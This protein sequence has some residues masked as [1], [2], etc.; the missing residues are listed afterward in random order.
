[1]KKFTSI[2][3]A[4]TV[5]LT[6][7]MIPNVSM[8]EAEKTKIYFAN[9]ALLETN[10][11]KFWEDVKEGFEAEN[12]EYEIEWIT[13]P[14][15]DIMTTSVT[16]IG[17]N[18]PV[19]LIFGEIDWVPTAQ[20]YGMS[21]PV[22]DIFDEDFLEDFYPSVL[23]A[24]KVDGDIYGL[25]LY[26]TPYVLYYNSEIFEEAGLEAPPTTYDEMLEYCEVIDGMTTEDGN[27]IYGFGQTTASVVISGSALQAMVANFGGHVLTE[28]GELDID[29]DGFK[30]AFTMLKTLNDNEY[31]P[32]NAKLK[33]LRNLFA[34]G[35]LAMYYDQSWGFSGV[36]G[37]NPDAVN[38]TESAAPLAG[39]EGDGQSVLQ[40]HCLIYTSQDPE[41]YEALQKL[42]AYLLTEDVLGPYL[43]E[44]TPAY[45]ATDS[46]AE[47][48]AIKDSKLLAGAASSISNVTSIPPI[49]QLAELNLEL[50]SLAQSVTLGNEDVDTAIENFRTT[51][52]DILN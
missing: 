37:I 41:N 32:E 10:Y 51:V 7:M 18:E 44:I 16:R 14:Y 36:Q 3:L 19:D 34:L 2:L 28:D 21:M 5:I 26:I 27:K 31:M 52:E 35:Q 48:D 47:M 4:L 40:S 49:P 25:P 22:E 6:M 17:S 46:L 45:P 39:G 38:F 30:E 50:T 11:T 8:A 42:T 15:A 24:F 1:M 13:A 23:D 33:D 43:S 20:D 29:N 12:P 9:Y